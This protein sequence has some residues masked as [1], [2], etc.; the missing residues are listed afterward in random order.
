MCF[1]DSGYI[2]KR[3]QNRK[4]C[5]LAHGSSK[6]SP[7]T[8]A[9]YARSDA[10][11]NLSRYV[12]LTR[13]LA[14]VRRSRLTAGCCCSRFVVANYILESPSSSKAAATAGFA[15]GKTATSCVG[16]SP[17]L[18]YLRFFLMGLE[19][20]KHIV[21][22]FRSKAFFA[23]V[24]CLPCSRYIWK[25]TQTKNI[26]CTSPEQAKTPDITPETPSFCADS[27]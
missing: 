14:L 2:W 20:W 8:D 11:H 15:E 9:G 1:Q 25:R 19:L 17:H 7:H 12:L 6:L 18:R 21:I 5:G 27:R 13:A 4:P 16:V 22:L 24:G 10:S 3:T 23:G 26:C